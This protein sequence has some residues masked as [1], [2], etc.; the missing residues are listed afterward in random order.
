MAILMVAGCGQ[1]GAGQGSGHES[2]AEP[3]PTPQAKHGRPEKPQTGKGEVAKK[4]SQEQK[5]HKHKQKP[6]SKPEPEPAPS[7]IPGLTPQDV[8]LNL[9]N[10]GFKCSEPK[11]MGHQNEVRW[12]CEKQEAQGEYLVK[13]DSS[14]ANSVRLVKARVISHDPAR[15]DA[16]AQDFLGYVAKVPY[17]GAQP[18][19][20]KAWVKQNV[21]SKVSAEFGGVSYTLGAKAGS[22]F[23]EL[24]KLEG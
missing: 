7:N 23:L 11:L 20:A 12:T 6:K 13:I 9:E 14:D 4:P 1:E 8:Y 24:E 19:E 17:E 21:G 2:T 22:R 16:L 18:E 5:Q 3:K 15:A 10:K